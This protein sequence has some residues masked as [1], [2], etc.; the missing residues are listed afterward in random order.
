MTF[1]TDLKYGKDAECL[2]L[3]RIQKK[4]PLAFMIEGKFKAFDLFVPEIEKGVEIKSDRQ[5]EQTGNVFIEIECNHEYS[6]IQTTKATWYVYQTK[7]R[8]FWV[9]TEAIRQYLISKAKELRLFN[10]TP[11]GEYS[12]VRGYLVPIDDFEKLSFHVDSEGEK[13]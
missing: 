2:I 4:Y 8:V 6:G 12:A 3:K 1:K 10:N 7:S 9:T 11:K 13:L 5:A